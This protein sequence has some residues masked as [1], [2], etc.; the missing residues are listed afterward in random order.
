MLDGGRTVIFPVTDQPTASAQAGW[1]TRGATSG[2]W[3]SAAPRRRHRPHRRRVSHFGAI[4]LFRRA[5]SSV[6][7]DCGGL[8]VRARA[9][10]GPSRSPRGPRRGPSGRGRRSSCPTRRPGAPTASDSTRCASP[11]R[12]PIRGALPITW[13]AAFPTRP[14]R[15]RR[16]GCAPRREASHRSAPAHSGRPVP[17]IAPTSPRPAAESS[18]SQR[19]CAATSPSEW[20]AHPSTLRPQQAGHPTWTTAARSGAHRTRCRPSPQVLRQ[21]EVPLGAHGERERVARHQVG[22]GRAGPPHPRRL[23]DAQALAVR[24]PRTKPSAST[25]LTVSVS[26]N[27]GTAASCPPR[28]AATTAATSAGGVSGRRASCLSRSEP[29]PCAAR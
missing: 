8:G 2:C 10:A 24:E 13:T 5:R 11:R 25:R 21:L 1:P 23:H 19:A 4:G 15:A 14:A 20:P 6:R 28:T 29:F 3:P 12:E 7:P 9:A 18:A 22:D 27:A 17:K 16:R 26:G